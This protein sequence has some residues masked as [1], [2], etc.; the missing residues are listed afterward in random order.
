M[1]IENIN[2]G[3]EER[4][5]FCASVSDEFAEQM[6]DKYSRGMLE[7]RY[8]D[9]MMRMIVAYF[10]KYH[11]APRE[12][13]ISFFNNAV[14]LKRIK[15]DDAAEIQLIFQAFA[16]QADVTDVDYE[17]NEAFNYLNAQNI[18]L[19]SEEAA[20]LVDEGKVTEAKEL[21]SSIDGFERITFDAKDIYDYT[22]DDF[23]K[24]LETTTE[25]IINVPGAAGLIMNDTL[26][27]NGFVTLIGRPKCGKSW[28]LMYLARLARN[29]GKR[30]IFISAGDMTKSQVVKRILQADACTS[31]K[32]YYLD[33]QFIPCLDCVKNQ[34]GTC[35]KREGDGSL[36]DD[37]NELPKMPLITDSRYKPCVDRRCPDYKEGV[38]YTQIHNPL[39]D[40]NVVLRMQNKW[41]DAE[42]SGKL[43][44]EY[45]PSG[46]L[47]IAK[48][49]ELIRGICKAQ[50]WLDDE[51]HPSLDYIIVDY[52]TILAKESGDYREALNKIW[53]S[54]KQDTDMFNCLVITA[55]HSN[56]SGFDF[57]DLSLAS[58]SGDNRIWNEVTAGFAINQTLEERR[59]SQ[60]RVAAL[61][62]RY[63]EYDEAKQAKCYGCLAVG[64]PHIVSVIEHHEPVKP[65]VFTK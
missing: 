59:D 22:E 28:W 61:I 15:N 42:N 5:V 19:A 63:S 29:Q 51:G 6:V 39:L 57:N 43:I 37:F 25:Q 23:R 58:F 50:G 49:R 33:K 1:K 38:S 30:G 31:D 47:T 27:R 3:M 7:N 24:A 60:W 32:P 34:K 36:V 10:K 13:F 26:V 54:L 46:T 41:K 17:I 35:M 45:A 48:R 64:T 65:K 4:I 16:N 21:L 11:K 12:S 62:K 52:A 8:L 20:N 14:T 53:Q 9:I 40:M 56:A 2:A 44:V 18:K 55:F